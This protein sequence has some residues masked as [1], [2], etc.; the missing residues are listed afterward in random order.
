MRIGYLVSLYPAASHTFIRREIEALRGRGLQ[1]DT[2]SIRSPAPADLKSE[3]DRSAQSETWYVLP[4]RPLLLLRDHAAT[5][6][7]DPRG[8]LRVLRLALSHRP[9]G[10]KAL[11]LSLAYFAEAVMLARELKRRSIG[12][13]H[14][15]FANAAGTVGL[16]TSTLMAIPWSL[17]LHGI[18]ETDYPAGV[19]LRRKIER[20]Q[21]VALRLPLR[22]RPGH[23][24]RAG[25]PVEQAVHFALRPAAGR[26]A[27]PGRPAGWRPAAGDMRRAPVGGKS[28]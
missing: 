3:Q 12:H 17:T 9:P 5:L 19:T 24:D 13:L 4:A 8:Y 23:A 1:I 22:A 6:A 18:S 21:F 20:A 15:H 14:A 11:A 28:A 25:E 26:S 27:G 7:A 10:L 2:F 16:L